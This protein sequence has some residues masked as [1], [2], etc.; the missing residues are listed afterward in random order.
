MRILGAT[1]ED[2]LVLILMVLC[3]FKN[4]GGM[5][6]IL[7]GSTVDVMVVMMMMIVLASGNNGLYE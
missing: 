1:K 2:K 3:T 4:D 5:Y 6:T 7:D